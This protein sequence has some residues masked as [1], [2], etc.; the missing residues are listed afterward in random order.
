M[1]V[2]L[3]YTNLCIDFPDVSTCIS[4][5]NYEGLHRGIR[6]STV[7]FD[8]LNILYSFQVT[9]LRNLIEKEVCLWLVSRCVYALYSACWLLVVRV[10]IGS[11]INNRWQSGL[12]K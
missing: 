11:I 2:A 10:F 5:I 12:I 9:T 8:S 1:I 6:S 4:P 7:W 3:S